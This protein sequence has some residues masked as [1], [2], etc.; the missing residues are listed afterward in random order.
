MKP[1]STESSSSQPFHFSKDVITS[2]VPPENSETDQLFGELDE[3]RELFDDLKNDETN[4]LRQI[5]EVKKRKNLQEKYLDSSS[6]LTLGETLSS[7]ETQLSIIQGQKRATETAIGENT[8]KLQDAQDR[9]QQEREHLRTLLD[10]ATKIDKKKQ[11]YDAVVARF[12]QERRRISHL[13]QWEQ[14][15]RGTWLA[16]PQANAALQQENSSTTQRNAEALQELERTMVS[17]LTSLAAEISSLQ[18]D[19]KKIDK[20]GEMIL[21]YSQ[22]MQEYTP[23]QSGTA[24]TTETPNNEAR[25]EETTPAPQPTEPVGV[26]MNEA[27]EYSD[28]LLPEDTLPPGKGDEGVSESAPETVLPGTE[29]FDL[30]SP[31]FD[32]LRQAAEGVDPNDALKGKPLETVA[33]PSR[34]DETQPQ[35]SSAALLGEFLRGSP[36]QRTLVLQ[37]LQTNFDTTPNAETAYHYIAALITE[38]SDL[39]ATWD[40]FDA[41]MDLFSTKQGIELVVGFGRKF[42]QLGNIEWAQQLYAEMEGYENFANSPLFQ[43][44]GRELNIALSRAEPPV[45]EPEVSPAPPSDE[46]EV[47]PAPPSGEPEVIPA[48]DSEEPLPFELDDFFKESPQAAETQ[49]IAAA[50]SQRQHETDTESDE[51]Y[52]TYTPA[53]SRVLKWR[54]E[55]QELEAGTEFDSYGNKITDPVRIARLKAEAITKRQDLLKKIRKEPKP[56]AYV[57]EAFGKGQAARAALD[58]KIEPVRRTLEQG[59]EKSKNMQARLKAMLQEAFTKYPEARLSKNHFEAAQGIHD[60]SHVEEVFSFMNRFSNERRKAAVAKH[61][62]DIITAHL[63]LLSY[64]MQI[65]DDPE[66]MFPG[67]TQFTFMDEKGEIKSVDAKMLS[68]FDIW[69]SMDRIDAA[70][71]G[72]L[73]PQVRAVMDGE[74][75]DVIDNEILE[76]QAFKQESQLGSQEFQEQLDQTEPKMNSM[77]QHKDTGEVYIVTGVS[78][79]T[80]REARYTLQSEEI[81]PLTGRKNR[82]E[83]TKDSLRST[84]SR[85]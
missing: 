46:P 2:I 68:E 28:I 31:D 3:L 66:I 43:T 76:R 23:P 14:S 85:M 12:D 55:I 70:F 21:F 40:L 49:E 47:I 33:S 7:L 19:L 73:T 72:G 79:G 63:Q 80:G 16:D 35:K 45:K 71:D 1:M 54:R 51:Y 56:S 27:T 65:N 25:S 52:L 48:P 38:G 42:L 30:D 75:D 74:L 78:S 32:M 60:K 4:V 17:E 81:N 82:T 6:S 57:D 13:G 61:K 84:F 20:N 34:E 58:G 18:E 36:E 64:R 26:A 29:S 5:D 24:P 39:G 69:E 59:R 50:E 83:R 15:R 9:I 37:Q 22:N 67:K 11:E 10:T 77:Y 41:N 44:F 53:S 62:N 8:R